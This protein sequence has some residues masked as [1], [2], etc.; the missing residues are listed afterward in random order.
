MTEHRVG[1]GA[2]RHAG[3]HDEHH[4]Q[5]RRPPRAAEQPFDPTG[6]ACHGRRSIA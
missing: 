6:L 4:Q 3:D 5:D 1:Q 2:D